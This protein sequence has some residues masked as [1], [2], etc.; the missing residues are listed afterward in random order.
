MQ[1]SSTWKKRFKGF[2]VWFIEALPL[3]AVIAYYSDV[4]DKT[5][6]F[7]LT[8]LKIVGLAV[9]ASLIW[10]IILIVVV[11]AFKGTRKGH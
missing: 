11:E 2:A 1:S 4:A 7:S 10:K 5:P 6:F 3:F 8:T 9:L